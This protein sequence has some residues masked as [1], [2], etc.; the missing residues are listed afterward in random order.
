M[1]LDVQRTLRDAQLFSTSTARAIEGTLI[2]RQMG[3]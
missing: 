2:A 3:L 1:G